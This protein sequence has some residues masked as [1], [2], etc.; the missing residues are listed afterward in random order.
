M[1]IPPVGTNCAILYGRNQRCHRTSVLEA[2]ANV[3]LKTKVR[4][5]SAIA[6]LEYACSCVAPRWCRDNDTVA[7]RALA[8]HGGFEVSGISRGSITNTQTH[9]FSVSAVNDDVR[10]LKYSMEDVDEDY[11]RR[12]LRDSYKYGKE[13][14]SPSQVGTV[15]KSVVRQ[16]NGTSLDGKCTYFL[17]ATSMPKW[18]AFAEQSGLNRVYT[19]AHLAI[20]QNQEVLSY[21]FDSLGEKAGKEASEIEEAILTGGLTPQQAKRLAKRAAAMSATLSE[22]ELGIGLH[23]GHFRVRLEQVRKQAAVAGLLAASV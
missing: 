19:V 2:L 16:L 7:V 1:N 10:L 21:L 9:L 15:V 6:A 23:L 4:H 17:L 22:Y 13:L 3:G 20:A 5:P 11:L 8:N 12:C 18:S 14:L